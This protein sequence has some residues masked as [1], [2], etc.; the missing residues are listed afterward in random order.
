MSDRELTYLAGKM[1]GKHH[2]NFTRFFQVAIELRRQGV[3]VWN[4]AEHDMA[5]GFDPTKTLDEQGWDIKGVMAVD[6]KALGKCD[7]I[8]LLP[9]WEDSFGAK[10]E[11]VLSWCTGKRVYQWAEL[12]EKRVELDLGRPTITFGKE[13]EPRLEKPQRC[14]HN[15]DAA[16]GYKGGPE[17]FENYMG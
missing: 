16:A 5:N 4:P 1:G 11:V 15:D 17:F 3:A 7:T 14:S 13:T 8:T 9:D 12:E 10:V 2:H 6:F